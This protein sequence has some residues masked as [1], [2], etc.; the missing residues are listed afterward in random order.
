MN[1]DKK[2]LVIDD[3]D[4]GY[5]QDIVRE[6]VDAPRGMDKVEEML[7]STKYH[8]ILM[9]GHLDQGGCFWYNPSGINGSELLKRI[10]DN[11]YGDTNSTTPIYSISMGSFVQGALEP[12]LNE[13][14]IESAGFGSTDSI[15]TLRK[16]KER[17]ILRWFKEQGYD[18]QE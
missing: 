5:I 8:A 14:I 1:N 7:S 9:D 10:R 4:F 11:Y 3:K 6:H 17:T 18:V 13:P 2:V 12:R 16:D 15:S